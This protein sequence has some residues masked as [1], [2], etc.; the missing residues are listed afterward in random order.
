MSGSPLFCRTPHDLIAVLDAGHSGVHGLSDGS[1]SLID[2]VE[3][4][5]ARWDFDSVALA[6]W[7]SRP[8]HVPRVAQL[9][10]RQVRVLLDRH[11][12]TMPKSRAIARMYT[13]TLGA[14]NVR[15]VNN[16]S[17]FA[18]FTGAE[19]VLYL[20]TANL[21]RNYRWESITIF[22]GGSVCEAYQDLVALIWRTVA[23]IDFADSEGMTAA[24][25]T[26]SALLAHGRPDTGV[27]AGLA[28]PAIDVFLKRLTQE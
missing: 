26:A 21:S 9:P 18:I 8:A 19:D 3:A 23:P 11:F 4:I 16:H 15:L 2:G 28:V 22:R 6:T 10:C 5:V 20:T 12:Y 7:R 17:K 27:D 13:D 25:D 1:W 24:A 14:D